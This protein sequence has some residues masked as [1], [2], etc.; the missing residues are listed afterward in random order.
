[1]EVFLG[2]LAALLLWLLREPR[3][4]ACLV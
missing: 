2:P 3:F 1:M 4:I